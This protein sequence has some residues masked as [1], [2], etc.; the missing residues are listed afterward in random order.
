MK[1]TY[2]GIVLALFTG[3]THAETVS[4][5]CYNCPTLSTIE[6]ADTYNSN[7]YYAEVLAAIA[8]G[9]TQ[10]EIKSALNAVISRNHKKLTYSEVWTALTETDEDPA[11]PD[12]VLLIYK[13]IS[14]PKF[15]N[16][17]GEQSSNPDNWNREHVW[18]K[19]HGFSS[20]SALAYSDIHHLRPSDISINS[21][22]SNYDF[23]NSDNPL[24][25]APANR[26]DSDS[27]EPR[28][29]VKGDV[30]RMMFY[31]DTRYEGFDATTPDLT[32]V[33]RITSSGEPNF[34]MLCR[35]I[36]WHKNDPVDSI[37]QARNNRIFEFQGNRNPFVDHPEWVET[38][39]PE[40]DCATSGGN[41]GGD[42]GGDT[43]G[44][45]GGDTGG[46][47]GG[48]TGGDTGGDSG[49]SLPATLIISE[50][51]EGSSYNKAIELYNLSASDIDFAAQSVALLRYSN[52]GTTATR[53]NLEGIVPAGSTFVIA[54]NRAND[55]ILGLAN[56]TS[57]SLSHNGDDAYELVVGDTVVDSFGRV[58][59]DP[60]SQWGTDTF[61]T[62]D[63]TLRRNGS[64]VTGDTNS[65][66]AFDP[67]L[68]W[69][70]SANDDASDLGLHTVIQTNLFISE[71]IEGSS[72]N[73]ALELYNPSTQAVDLAAQGYRL[74]RFSNGSSSG[75]AIAL[76][77][78]VEGGDVFV[79][80]NGGAND[81]IKA[82][83]DQ[84][85]NAIAH[86]GDDAYV[87]YKG[88]EVIDVFGQV[89][90]DPGSQWGVAPNNTK[91]RTLIR[92]PTISAGYTE[93]SQPFDPSVEWFG[94]SNND[95]TNL[96]THEVN[97]G[98]E[99]P[100]VVSI[101]QCLDQAQLISAIQ[102]EGEVSPL[103][104]ETVVVEAVVTGV[105]PSL[106]G[107]F[108]QEQI[109]DQDQNPMTSEGVFVYNPNEI[110][111][112]EGQV[113]RV[114]GGVSERYGKT[115]ITLTQA[116]LDCGVDSVQTTELVLPFSSNEA[117]ESIEGML[118]TIGSP[119]TVTDN[120]NLGRYGEVTLS[121]GRLFAPTNL[122]MPGSEE[123]AQLT[124]ENELNKV[125]LDDGV[126]G[127]NPQ[128]T[129]YPAGGLSADNSLRTGDQVTQLTGVI[130]Y[131]FG[132]YRVVPTTEPVIEVTNPR[133]DEPQVEQIGNLRIV[134]ANVLNLFNGD[135]QG[136][137]FPTPRGAD[138]ETEYQRQ[139][140][141]IVSAL[142]AM[143]ADI[144]ALQEIE[145]DGFGEFSAIQEL[146]S[147]L[148][149]YA[150]SDKD[151]AFV[152]PFAAGV[153]VEEMGGDAI[154]VA[155]IYNTL[156]VKEVG[157]AATILD[158]PFEYHNRPPLAQTFES[159]NGDVFTVVVTHFR[160]KGCSSS[161]GVENE[162]K[163]DGQGCYNLRRVQASE[164][165]LTWLET[166]PTGVQDED[167]IMLGDFNAYNKEDP[168]TSLVV[169]GYTDL[170]PS[171]QGD[172]SYT[173]SIFGQ[174]G[175][176]DHALTS[177]SMTDKV[178]N[179]TSWAINADEPRVLDYNE[180]YKSDEQK[181]TLYSDGPFRASDHDPIVI[182][183]ETETALVTTTKTYRHL[184]FFNHWRVFAVKVPEGATE[185]NV[186]LAGGFGNADLF[187]RKGRYP[188]RAKFD[189][190]SRQRGNNE[191]CTIA[192]PEP[193]YWFVRVKGR[194]FYWGPSLTIA[195]THPKQ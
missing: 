176:L 9:Q 105:F 18:A 130:D 162:D 156:A 188:N 95:A 190:A 59:E 37:E 160:S 140:D 177:Q 150:G 155:L 157:T 128:P 30:A 193:G 1:T 94:T 4:N 119:L 84:L 148:N 23:D 164:A 47:T 58:G 80:A 76:E 61:K 181:V 192:N 88:T 180:E 63:N 82:Q 65:T 108:I 16:G 98:E 77:G 102:G 29:A 118:V 25:E 89:G 139:L 33:N 182:D 122:F 73:K 138:S 66:D 114:L 8:N 81:E 187:V 7:E 127:Q 107:F 146:V 48:N 185:L 109:S 68:E 72:Y 96:G 22:R 174:V 125:L 36:E 71:Y 51:I 134:N 10:L 115:Q 171:F 101:G 99:T 165:I 179:A 117:K 50:Y 64:V 137:G 120:Y 110:M 54:N 3:A 26:V 133:T 124:A 55:E 43:G 159:N 40:A 172:E 158:F 116:P 12:N 53:I 86:N 142:T 178:V 183:I 69:I 92:K 141:K 41:T 97:G 90:V 186:N 2:T 15:N 113:I 75:Y 32:L 168:I 13:G 21:S 191:Q 167:V 143:N 83:A 194:P 34:G 27:F 67:A 173:Y 85:T 52:G 35:L 20:S 74:E 169:A 78:I 103:D 62:K 11:N 39:F 14:I 70:G 149:Q 19:S 161:G 151:Y 154:K 111:P 112:T 166:T 121:N 49:S 189:C 46:D 104:G 6:N 135:G 28:D 147:V 195:T 144:I 5:A 31:M 17:S 100:P 123:V 153:G 170:L 42:T 163:G 45:T 44:N 175:A 24:S 38:I 57:G 131:S 91:D 126:N 106:D 145:N 132:E 79:I 136:A 60:G 129:R 93:L 152:Q 184:S 56:L 87:L